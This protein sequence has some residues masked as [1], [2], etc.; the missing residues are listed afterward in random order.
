MT[1]IQLNRVDVENRA[2]DF[3]NKFVSIEGTVIVSGDNSY[4]EVGGSILVQLNDGSLVDR[5]L[6][7]V[8]CYVG[9][10]YLYKDAATLQGVL[11]VENGFLQ[12]KCVERV[13][14]RRGDQ[15]FEF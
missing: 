9:G 14:V 5:F 6:D 4:L 8:P 3:N 2:S 10:Q 7:H 15:T 1:A 12:I 13:S 11:H